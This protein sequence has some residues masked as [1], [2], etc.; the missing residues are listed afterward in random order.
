MKAEKRQH[1]TKSKSCHC[2]SLMTKLYICIYIHIYCSA[3]NKLTW[4]MR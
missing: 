2:Q 4:T 3:C 1:T